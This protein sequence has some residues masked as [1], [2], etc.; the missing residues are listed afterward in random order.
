M[1]YIKDG[2]T[3]PAPFNLIPAPNS[4]FKLLKK[5]CKYLKE[6]KTLNINPNENSKENKHDDIIIVNNGQPFKNDINLKVFFLD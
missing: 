6:K 5:F 1:Q 3:L 4:I 2:F